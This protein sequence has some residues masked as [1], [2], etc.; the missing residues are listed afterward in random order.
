MTQGKRQYA[1]ATQGVKKETRF[2][3]WDAYSTSGQ[4]V[5][6][7]QLLNMARV[8]FSLNVDM[9]NAYQ[10]LKERSAK[11]RKCGLFLYRKNLNPLFAAPRPTLRSPVASL[12]PAPFLLLHSPVG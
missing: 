6:W 9:L 11:T 4:R 7:R 5:A 8:K 3:V 2:G 12:C 1:H 10:N